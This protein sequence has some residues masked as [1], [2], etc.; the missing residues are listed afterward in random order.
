MET[1]VGF[2][3]WGT[4]SSRA[5]DSPNGANLTVYSQPYFLKLQIS[6]STCQMVHF[7]SQSLL[8]KWY[9][10]PVSASSVACVHCRSGRAVAIATTLTGWLLSWLESPLQSKFIHYF[11]ICILSCF[12]DTGRMKSDSWAE[13]DVSGFWDSS[14]QSFRPSEPHELGLSVCV[15]LGILVCWTAVWISYSGVLAHPRLL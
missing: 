10:F 9:I 12:Q 14:G 3:S 5:R 13:Y 2:C 7:P 8:V 6:F 11:R 15:S 1:S 4:L